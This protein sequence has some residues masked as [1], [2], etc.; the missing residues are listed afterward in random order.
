LLARPKEEKLSEEIDEEVSAQEVIASAK[1]TKQEY[2]IKAA[3]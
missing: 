2:P 3:V 1:K